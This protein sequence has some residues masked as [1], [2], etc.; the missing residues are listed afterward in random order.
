ML[1]RCWSGKSGSKMFLLEMCK[2]I[3]FARR[4]TFPQ[5]KDLQTGVPAVQSR[6]SL[7]LLFF[8]TFSLPVLAS[9][10]CSPFSH[11]ILIAKDEMLFHISLCRCL[12]VFSILVAV[13]D[14]VDIKS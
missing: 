14:G 13:S 3:K 8:L 5:G 9:T 10:L 12:L 7:L 2:N 11:L 1:D 6:F 4:D